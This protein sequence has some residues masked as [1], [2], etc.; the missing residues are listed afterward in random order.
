MCPSY[1]ANKDCQCLPEVQ[2]GSGASCQF[3]LECIRQCRLPSWLS[4]KESFCQCTRP[5]F[6]LWVGKIPWR[7]KRQ[8]I[9]AWEISCTEEPGRL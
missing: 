4:G 1:T 9:L 8:S 2:Q 7:R 3:A 6:S 5:K